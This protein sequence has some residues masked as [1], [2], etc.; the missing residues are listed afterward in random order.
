M[1]IYDCIDGITTFCPRCE[2]KLTEDFHTKDFKDMF[3]NHYAPGDI[4]PNERRTKQSLNVYTSCPECGMYVSL[5]LMIDGDMLTY[6]ISKV[7]E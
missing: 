4:V 3:L 7:E 1:G 2:K 6:Q 5:C